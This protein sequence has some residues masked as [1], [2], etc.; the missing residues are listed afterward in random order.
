[1]VL[2]ILSLL[3]GSACYG[4]FLSNPSGGW[5]V[6]TC[7]VLPDSVLLDDCGGLTGLDVAE[8]LGGDGRFGISPCLML[9]RFL[10]RQH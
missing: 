7:G 2:P 9:G 6:L 1:M 10:N 4:G 3:R 5:P 8:G